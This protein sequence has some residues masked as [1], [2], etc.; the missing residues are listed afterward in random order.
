MME[1]EREGRDSEGQRKSVK[2]SQ[3]NRESECVRERKETDRQRERERERVINNVGYSLLWSDLHKAQLTHITHCLC[4]KTGERERGGEQ[5]RDVEGKGGRKEREEGKR[6][7][8]GRL[9]GQG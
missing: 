1:K 6:G 2:D 4:N 9:E 7:R 5:R 8:E 3:K